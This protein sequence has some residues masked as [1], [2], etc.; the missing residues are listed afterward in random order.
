M[1]RSLDFYQSLGC[2]VAGVA[3]G[4]VQLRLCRA[5]LVL[6]QSDAPVSP[7]A[8]SVVLHATDGHPLVHLLTLAGV[9]TA[10]P[11]VTDPPVHTALVTDPDGHV[12]RITQ[13]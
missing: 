4:W 8:A 13:G 1:S 12:L 3:D 10:V 6:Y 5:R 9:L 2:E 11:G 7:A